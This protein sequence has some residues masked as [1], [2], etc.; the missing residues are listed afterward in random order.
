[1]ATWTGMNCNEINVK[2]QI[3]VKWKNMFLNALKEDQWSLELEKYDY[4]NL[5]EHDQECVIDRVIKI[6][7]ISDNDSG[8][9]QA[10]DF[11]DVFFYAD[12]TE[13]PVGVVL[14]NS[15]ITAIEK[16]NENT[17][18][19]VQ[20]KLISFYNKQSNEDRQKINDFFTA[21]S[22][23]QLTTLSEMTQKNTHEKKINN[24]SSSLFI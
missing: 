12:I 20:L 4:D 13:Q 10:N 1:M 17:S 2:N 24:E 3:P 9:E 11:A 16:W 5:Y 6:L 15:L 21:I 18:K 22:G 7:D 19:T 14:N 8:F 23:F